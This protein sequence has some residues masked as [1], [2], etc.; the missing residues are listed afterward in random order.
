MS[1][2]WKAGKYPDRHV[3]QP[4]MGLPLP[5]STVGLVI[6][7]QMSTRQA[8]QI[9]DGSVRW[10]PRCRP[11]IKLDKQEALESI[12]EARDLG[13][14]VQCDRWEAGV[15]SIV[16]PLLNPAS[17]KFYGISVSG[18]TD[19]IKRNLSKIAE[20]IE[21]SRAGHLAGYSS[22]KRQKMLSADR[23]QH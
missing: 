13:H 14:L 9:I 17:G 5:V 4:G 15:G 8:E 1:S 20:T 10:M 22:S 12:H 19:R 21:F 6:L 23:H 7:A 18:P 3:I 11:D 16:Y 2:I